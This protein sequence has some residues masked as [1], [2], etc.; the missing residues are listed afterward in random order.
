MSSNH[1]DENAASSSDAKDDNESVNEF[2][3]TFLEKHAP[4]FK[5]Q[6]DR[7][8]KENLV[9]RSKEVNWSRKDERVFFY[10]FLCLSSSYQKCFQEKKKMKK[11]NKKALYVVGFY[12]PKTKDYVPDTKKDFELSRDVLEKINAQLIGLPL[13]VEHPKNGKKTAK[14]YP[15]SS[16]GTIVSSVITKDGKAGFMARL[17]DPESIECPKQYLRQMSVNCSVQCEN[18]TSIG[19]VSLTHLFFYDDRDPENTREY[20]ADHIAL[21]TEGKRDG[22]KVLKRFYGDADKVP[23]F[24][25]LG[26]PQFERSNL[27]I[28]NASNAGKPFHNVDVSLTKDNLISQQTIQKNWNFGKQPSILNSDEKNTRFFFKDPN[29]CQKINNHQ[30]KKE[31]N[32]FSLFP[33][34]KKIMSA[35][36]AKNSDSVASE[37]GTTSTTTSTSAERTQTQTPLSNGGGGQKRGVSFKDQQQQQ[38]QATPP[39]NEER[40]KRVRDEVQRFASE[41]DPEKRA[42]SLTELSD[43]IIRILDERDGLLDE[44]DKAVIQQKRKEME[45][46]AWN[47]GESLSYAVLSEKIDECPPGSDELELYAPGSE[48]QKLATE[49]FAKD[50]VNRLGIDKASTP[51]DFEAI[52]TALKSNNHFVK[53]IQAASKEAHSKK[54]YEKSSYHQDV[55]RKNHMQ[56]QKTFGELNGNRSTFLQEPPGKRQ[57]TAPNPQPPQQ[58]SNCRTASGDFDKNS[59][60]DL[61]KQRSGRGSLVNASNDATSSVSLTKKQDSI[62][63]S[64]AQSAQLPSQQGAFNKFHSEKWRPA[65][66]RSFI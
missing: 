10:S 24:E 62:F 34:K 60:F 13:T 57:R 5:E 29:F 17:R 47:I 40:K 61:M 58:Q 23:R 54:Y 14:E 48:S 18:I 33:W 31:K 43:F 9:Q 36:N 38:Q 50:F 22:C 51:E 25:D 30:E 39:Q 1:T 37:S 41:K 20:F 44:K 42:Q 65:Q 28:V 63:E 2:M 53:Q 64:L 66:R 19:E 15:H 21:C 7:W 45:E 32:Q 27:L 6:H 49:T 3:D 52:K 11:S 12:H 4:E 16:Y 56:L 35:S 55:L 26:I 59:L 8:N 46:D